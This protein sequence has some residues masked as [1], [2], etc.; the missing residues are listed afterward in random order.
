MVD[1]EVP[2]ELV[3]EA[4][5]Q[6]TRLH[7]LQLSEEAESTT[8]EY[9]M[10][11]FNADEAAAEAY[12]GLN[13][14]KD[15]EI[16]FFART[17]AETE[18]IASGMSDD[19]IISC[20]KAWDQTTKGLQLATIMQS[21]C[22][23][24]GVPA[25]LSNL[26]IYAYLEK[27]GLGIEHEQK[28]INDFLQHQ[29]E[30]VRCNDYGNS[31]RLAFDTIR[32]E[33]LKATEDIKNDPKNTLLVGVDE[34]DIL[35]QLK[36]HTVHN[37]YKM[38]YRGRDNDGDPA[39][40]IEKWLWVFDKCVKVRSEARLYPR[41]PADVVASAVKS[42]KMVVLDR[43]GGG[44][45]RAYGTSFDD[46]YRARKRA[47]TATR[48]EGW[49]IITDADTEHPRF[50][51]STYLAEEQDYSQY[52]PPPAP[53]KIDPEI[54]YRGSLSD[55]IDEPGWLDRLGYYFYSL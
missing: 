42:I 52:I 4:V 23:A 5:Q 16:V 41:L 46:L 34:E 18:H 33:Y 24:I 50:D 22:I 15:A 7:K 14:T 9:V 17:S 8:V 53:L 47:E 43:G 10:R 37:R 20:Y 21:V 39:I 12:C 45:R 51:T 40:E 49:P 3:R 28:I 31:A 11:L 6:V 19:E 55:R 54:L 13:L 36:V 48:K 29:E 25:Q 44:V 32:A 38:W 1:P 35:R 2:E 30:V 27:H 26:N